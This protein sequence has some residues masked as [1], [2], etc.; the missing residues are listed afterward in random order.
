MVRRG[1]DAVVFDWARQLDGCRIEEVVPGG[2]A[3]L[4]G[5]LGIGTPLSLFGRFQVMAPRRKINEF[6]GVLVFGQFEPSG[7]F[8]SGVASFLGE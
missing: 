8:P 7:L 2:P 5:T 4:S 6:S 3:C 1:T